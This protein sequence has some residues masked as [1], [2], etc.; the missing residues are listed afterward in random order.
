MSRMTMLTMLLC[1]ISIVVIFGENTENLEVNEVYMGNIKEKPE[2]PP[3]AAVSSALMQ[4]SKVAVV[5]SPSFFQDE[6]QK[7]LKGLS[8]GV[9]LHLWEESESLL[10]EEFME[11]MEHSDPQV[12]QEQVEQVKQIEH[13]QEV[14]EV[15]EV[16]MDKIDK[17]DNF[18]KLR[19]GW[20]GWLL[21]LRSLLLATVLHLAWLGY[22]QYSLCKNSMVS[23]VNGVDEIDGVDMNFD[24]TARCNGADE[25]WFSCS[26]LHVAA[27]DANLEEMRSLLAN[28]AVTDVKAAV[29]AVDAW[30]ET[31]LH[32]A[33][34]RGSI[35][36]CVLLLE[37]KADVNARNADDETPLAVLTK[38]KDAK[39]DAKSQNDFDNLVTLSHLLFSHG[40]VLG[41]SSTSMPDT[42]LPMPCATALLESLLEMP[43]GATWGLTVVLVKLSRSHGDTSSRTGRP[44]DTLWP[45]R[46]SHC[47]RLRFFTE[48]NT[49]FALAALL[50]GF[51]FSDFLRFLD[52]HMC[53]Q[54]F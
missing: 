32:M 21:V 50:M 4:A 44:S 3:T 16:D 23:P 36:A 22:S 47:R 30:D 54:W 24:K 14:D 35:A 26:A 52:F 1:F 9:G 48:K 27:A 51:S 39:N 15:D 2:K 18:P 7:A 49:S 17:I 46:V 25:A 53:L 28:T 42:A 31:P 43:R 38:A 5:S 33:V 29:N 34:R 10:I 8:D 12:S 41:D 13:P 40:A 45:T 37:A 6:S 19:Q 20:S 11:H